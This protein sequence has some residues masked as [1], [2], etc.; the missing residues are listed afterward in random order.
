[1]D[2]H[3]ERIQDAYE[4]LVHTITLHFIVNPQEGQAITKT[5]LINLRCPTLSDY[6]WYKDVFF[7]NILKREDGM[8]NF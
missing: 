8:Q 2:E 7:T 5:T 3:G 6:R 4:A 1:L